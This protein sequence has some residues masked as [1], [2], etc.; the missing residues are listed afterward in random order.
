MK[1]DDQLQEDVLA[2]LRWD[3]RINA[4]RIAV[5]A[6]EGVVTITGDVSSFAEKVAAEKAAQRIAGVR[7]L[8]EE[9]TV[10]LPAS[11]MRDDAAVAR[12]VLDTLD[13]HAELSGTA[14]RVQVETGAVTLS[15][16]VS[17]RFQRNM[18][19]KCITHVHGIRSIANLIEVHNPVSV[20]DVR[21]EIEAAFRRLADL[22]TGAVEARVDGSKVVLSGTVFSLHEANVAR[23]AAWAAP[24]VT[25]VEDR[26]RVLG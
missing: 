6:R 19:A 4:P 12:R 26:I 22:N 11:H 15:G 10:T 14:I 21:D 23:E 16:S 9:L 25:D 5:T 20:L 2:E 1:S 17:W 24:G 8:V 13:H 3:P 18:A 7:A